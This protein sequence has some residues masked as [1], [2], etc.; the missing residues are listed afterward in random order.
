MAQYPLKNGRPTISKRIGSCSNQKRLYSSNPRRW[1][2]KWWLTRGALLELERQN[3]LRPIEPLGISD[4]PQAFDGDIRQFARLGGPDLRDIVGL[5][6]RI[7]GMGRSRSKT[8]TKPSRRGRKPRKTVVSL[9][10]SPYDKNF[11]QL[12][13]DDGIHMTHRDKKPDNWEKI[14]QELTQ[15][16]QSPSSSQ[17]TDDQFEAF[18]N[19][20]DDATSEARVLN[21]IFPQLLGDATIPSGENLIFN[22]LDPLIEGITTARPDFY[23]GIRSKS[24]DPQIRN[25]LSSSIV[26]SKQSRAPI[27]PT[28]FIEAKGPDGSMA[29]G[30]RQACYYGALG[31]RAF[32]ELQS[33]CR[34]QGGLSLDS[35]HTI[36]ST[37]QNGYLQ[38]YT[39]HITADDQYKMT[40]LAS[41]ALMNSRDSF[42]QGV[43]ALRNAREWAQKEREAAVVEA[44]R[45]VREASDSTTCSSESS[46]S[47]SEE[48]DNKNNSKSS[49]HSGYQTRSRSRAEG[50]HKHR[51]SSGLSPL[52]DR[53][54]THKP[55][56]KAR[57]GTRSRLSVVTRKRRSKFS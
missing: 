5:S 8:Q 7:E 26:P 22:N 46:L 40:P 4:S 32:R 21:S 10:A 18:L 16:T 23:D 37:Y 47:Y 17:F 29:V 27:L 57:A 39:V 19:A 3:R 25:D 44:N 6:A 41:F 45:R 51:T 50:I 12:L 24:L 31:A 2:S 30:K 54:S 42:A 11:E 9:K 43:G 13:S 52:R 14:I 55:K 35:A 49:G 48:S 53:S 15:E 56:L 1:P 34:R 20:M 38:L 28:F 36:T 33:Y